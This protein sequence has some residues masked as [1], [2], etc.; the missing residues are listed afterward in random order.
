[1]PE[2]LPQTDACE[3]RWYSPRG[4]AGRWEFWCWAVGLIPLCIVGIFLLTVGLAWPVLWY[5]GSGAGAASAVA[6]IIAGIVV[7]ISFFPFFMM[8][9]R[10][11]R[12]VGLNPLLAVLVWGILTVS[13]GLWVYAGF[14]FSSR[15][16]A[17]ARPVAEKYDAAVAASYQSRNTAGGKSLRNE[18]KQVLR[19]LVYRILQEEF[20][21]RKGLYILLKVSG[22]VSALCLFSLPVTG[23]LPP[24][25]HASELNNPTES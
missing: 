18:E 6:G 16:L 21:D 7:I 13:G 20:Q 3:T 17:E 23:L 4:R 12:D 25:R 22:L 1:M 15:I 19:A 9:C 11:L 5:C 2:S 24:R 14:E 10:R 8:L